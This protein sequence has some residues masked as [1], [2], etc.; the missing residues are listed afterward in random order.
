M[1]SLSKMVR[2]EALRRNPPARIPPAVAAVSSPATDPPVPD[3]AR[4]EP[5][6]EINLTPD[7][8]LTPGDNLS[9]GDKLK[10][11]FILT[12]GQTVDARFVRPQVLAQDG[13]TP[14]EHVVYLCLWR[15]PILSEDLRSHEASVYGLAI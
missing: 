1:A 5:R 7:D 15:V 10:S 14:S 2:V 4:P 3:A 8:K 12:D 9:P 6:P 11:A 13:H